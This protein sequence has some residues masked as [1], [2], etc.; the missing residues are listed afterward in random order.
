MSATR[1]RYQPV[2]LLGIAG[3]DAVGNRISPLRLTIVGQIRPK[4]RGG[5]AAIRMRR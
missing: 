4:M 5:G 1:L 3:F 2:F